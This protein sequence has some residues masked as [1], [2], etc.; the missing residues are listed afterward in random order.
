MKNNDTI[1]DS[2]DKDL[3]D[4]RDV[5]AVQGV[6]ML[7]M[8]YVSEWCATHGT[9]VRLEKVLAEIAPLG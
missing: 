2:A 7:D 4:A 5:L 1:L 9:T 6:G 3:D 8:S